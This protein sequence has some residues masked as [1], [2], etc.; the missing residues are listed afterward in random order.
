MPTN[1]GRTRTRP[2]LNTS[3][4][5]LDGEIRRMVIPGARV[6]RMVVT[7]EPADASRPMAMSPSPTMKR[8]TIRLSP[9][10]VPPLF[11]SATTVMTAPTEPHPEAGKAET[12]ED[13][14]SCAHLQGH[15]RDA[16]GHRERQQHGEDQTNA[17]GIEQ[18]RED[19]HVE[20]GVG[21]VESFDRHEDVD[22]ND[23]EEPDEPGE[24]VVPT[25]HLVV[26]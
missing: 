21:T 9:P 5:Q 26:G 14:R 23:R 25:D 11:T 2:R 19:L 17:L 1:T 24:E 20:G 18:L 3:A 16:H 4:D 22:D 13:D 10:S 12:G 8:S 6:V 7:T 15:E